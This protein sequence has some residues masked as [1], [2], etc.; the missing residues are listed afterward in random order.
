MLH[1]SCTSLPVRYTQVTDPALHCCCNV[2]GLVA[3]WPQ[4]VRP[5]RHVGGVGL[6][7][8]SSRMHEPRQAPPYLTKYDHA[9][10]AKAFS[11]VTWQSGCGGFW[12][13]YL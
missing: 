7:G 6:G 2:P 3:I 8:F 12:K 11:A 9:R 4:G 10:F 1:A 5:S 13:G